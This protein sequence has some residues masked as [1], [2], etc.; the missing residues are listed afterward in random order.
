MTEPIDFERPRNGETPD[1]TDINVR[2]YFSRLDD[3][4]FLSRGRSGRFIAILQ[5]ELRPGG[6]KTGNLPTGA[7]GLGVLGMIC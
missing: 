2:A 1:E 7:A 4:H 5:L 3:E 6:Q